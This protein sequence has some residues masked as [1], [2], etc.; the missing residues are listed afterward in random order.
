MR[1]SSCPDMSPMRSEMTMPREKKAV[2]R[3]A[4]VAS[5]ERGRRDAAVRA[6]AMRAAHTAPPGIMAPRP[7]TA[8]PTT[9]PGKTPWH[10]GLGAELCSAQVNERRGRA[11]REREQAQ[12]DDRAQQVGGDHDRDAIASSTLDP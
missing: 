6:A 2:S 9:M 11:R 1:D 5:L 8:M 7:P 10:H 12:D 3:T 4:V